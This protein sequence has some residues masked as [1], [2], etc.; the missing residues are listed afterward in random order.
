MQ[1]LLRVSLQL[2][3]FALIAACANYPLGMTEDEWNRLSPQQ[4]LDARE[5]QALLNQA[6]H[7]RRAE[8]ARHKAEQE[9]EEQQRY[10]AMLA[11]AGPGDIVQCV[12]QNGEGYYG[13]SWHPAEPVGFSLLRNYT[14][15]VSFAEQG[16][17]TR[18]I[19]TELTYNGANIRVCRLNNRDC[20]NVAA[21]QNQL[22]NGISQNI[23]VNR[24]IRGTLYCDIPNHD[25]VR[26]RPQQ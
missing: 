4:Q 21:T 25:R 9:R 26:Y 1:C 18:S 11:N 19:T 23:Q 22:R 7:A 14:Q 2:V 8:A 10:Q 20:S 15:T 3:T 6:E 5:R 12:L 13:S 24:A 17:P 16:R